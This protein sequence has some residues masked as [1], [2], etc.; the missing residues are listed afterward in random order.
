MGVVQVEVKKWRLV[1]EV[2]VFGRNGDVLRRRLQM[3][4]RVPTRSS[5]LKSLLGT[6]RLCDICCPSV[7]ACHEIAF[8]RAH[9]VWK[10]P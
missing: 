5:L 2:R 6:W 9:A 10:L 7:H 1:L 3:T 4:H 8:G